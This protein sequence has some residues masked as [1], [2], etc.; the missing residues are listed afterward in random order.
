MKY[1]MKSGMRCDWIRRIGH[2]SRYGP[3]LVRIG[4]SDGDGNVVAWCL[5]VGTPDHPLA[6]RVAAARRDAL[7]MRPGGSAVPELPVDIFVK[8]PGQPLHGFGQLVGI[9]FDPTVATPTRGIL[10]AEPDDRE[11]IGERWD[12]IQ[13]GASFLLKEIVL[14]ARP[15]Q[16]ASFEEVDRWVHDAALVRDLQGAIV[17]SGRASSLSQRPS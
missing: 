17:Y 1:G 5:V 15:A 12:A 13:R 16:T 9:S 2:A 4:T 11:V 14:P 10:E 3:N 6:V 8:Q 7:W